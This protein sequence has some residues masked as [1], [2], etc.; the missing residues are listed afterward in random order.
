MTSS[1]AGLAVLVS[2]LCLGVAVNGQDLA[3]RNPPVP[4]KQM[5]SRE[6]P[7]T[8]ELYIGGGIFPPNYTVKLEGASLRYECH[9]IDRKT[10]QPKVRSKIITP[11]AAQWRQ[12][13][14]S[15]DEIGLWKWQAEY[16][17]PLVMDGCGWSLDV[18]VAGKRVKS[19]GHNA[20]PNRRGMQLDSA[21]EDFEK[22]MNAVEA[23]LGDEP[24]H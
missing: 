8:F 1:R 11:T 5:P 16:P 12:F 15:M 6:L 3:G 4:G 21:S 17:N 20:Y 24:F 23:L 19:S 7:S 14:R 22:Y 10:E 13:W 9:D 2:L 18:A